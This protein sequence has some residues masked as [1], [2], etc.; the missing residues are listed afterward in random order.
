MQINASEVLNN[1]TI[2]SEV[3]FEYQLIFLSSENFEGA[4]TLHS[5]KFSTNFVPIFTPFFVIA[6]TETLSTLRCS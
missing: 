3:G 2:F 6:R 5:G 1:S 4:Y